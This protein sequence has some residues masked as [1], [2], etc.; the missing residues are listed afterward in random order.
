MA[1][2]RSFTEQCKTIFGPEPSL[3]PLFV[4]ALE[5]GQSGGSHSRE[6]FEPLGVDDEF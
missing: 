4:E 1:A 2:T 6:R 5:S 3:V